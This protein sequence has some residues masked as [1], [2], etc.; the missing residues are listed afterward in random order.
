MLMS[1]PANHL[2][3]FCRSVEV[4]YWAHGP[5]ERSLGCTHPKYQR[6]MAR[7]NGSCCLFE[8]EPGADDELERELRWA[9]EPLHPMPTPGAAQLFTGTAPVHMP[10]P[11]PPRK[12]VAALTSHHGG[13]LPEAGDASAAVG[14]EM[15][16]AYLVP[17]VHR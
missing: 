5:H 6:G 17:F 10:P 14:D 2:C 16:R 15:S 8:R 4:K 7:E 1:G 11:R 12:P 9:N 3:I 13:L